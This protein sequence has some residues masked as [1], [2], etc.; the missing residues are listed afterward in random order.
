M[1]KV[2]YYLGMG[3][4][5]L[6]CQSTDV[7]PRSGSFQNDLL[8][9]T[10]G[11]AVVG[12]RIEF[13]YAIGTKEGRLSQVRVEASVAGDGQ[14]TGFSKYSWFTNRDTGVDQPVQTASDT[15][16]SGAVSTATI[17]DGSNSQA[18]TLRYYYAPTEE[19]RGKEVSFR[20]SATNAAG[21]EVTYQS[22]AYRIS[23]MD[24]KRLIPLTD[25]G[26][27]YVSI[28]DMA[29]YTREEVE[30]R[31]LASKIDFVYIYRPAIGSYPFGH[32]WVAPSS[33]NY[34]TDV[35]LPTGVNAR[36]VMDKRIDVK[37]AQLRGTPGFDV[38]IDDLD[39]ERTTFTNAA[40]Y[41]FGLSADQGAFMKSADG[42]YVTYVYVNSV[43]N[44]ARSMIISFKR[45]R[46][47]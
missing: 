3:W 8:K 6:G 25:G 4:L 41:V 1:K 24:M 40:D 42:A 11:P 36:T 29:A 27:A 32:A 47:N 15:L 23:R 12:D 28:A 21:Q 16:T 5:L 34:L 39:L 37:D 14:G 33:R 2:M 30:Q 35:T 20:F 31:N 9:K 7:A 46:L 17:L 26:R 44:T 19:A 38:Y 45:L 18:V 22:P 10:T 13:A 43:N